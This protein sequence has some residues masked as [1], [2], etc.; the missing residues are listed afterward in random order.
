MKKKALLVSSILIGLLL[1]IGC[2]QDKYIYFNVCSSSD[3]IGIY[4]PYQGGVIKIS[5]DEKLYSRI[6]DYF[7]KTDTKTFKYYDGTFRSCHTSIPIVFFNNGVRIH[8]IE[9]CKNSAE[10]WLMEDRGRK[11]I[12]PKGS[13]DTLMNDVQQF[14]YDYVYNKDGYNSVRFP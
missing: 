4:N 5:K 9:M 13:I 14:T 11:Y 8:E 6:C 2:K 10:G 12:C 1:L 7:S 3:T